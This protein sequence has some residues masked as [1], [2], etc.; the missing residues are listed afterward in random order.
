MLLGWRRFI[1]L[2]LGCDFNSEEMVSKMTEY[3]GNFVESFGPTNNRYGQGLARPLGK[4]FVWKNV[5]RDLGCAF[6]QSMTVLINA[7]NIAQ[8]THRSSLG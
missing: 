2:S 4:K 1:S 3:A 5:I 6:A 7:S 8:R